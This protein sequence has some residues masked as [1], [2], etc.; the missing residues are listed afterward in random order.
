MED[1]ELKKPMSG[2]QTEVIRLNRLN[3]LPFDPATNTEPL[4]FNS[5]LV[6]ECP[7]LESGAESSKRGR[8]P[9]CPQCRVLRRCLSV[10]PVSEVSRSR[11]RLLSSDCVLSVS[12]PTAAEQMCFCEEKSLLIIPSQL[13]LSTEHVLL[14][15]AMC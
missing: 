7:P 13:Q 1:L 4:Q 2:V 15:R 14:I 11:K 12:M 10:W 3:S 9:L 5:S 6:S 8:C